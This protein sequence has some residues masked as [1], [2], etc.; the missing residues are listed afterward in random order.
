MSMKKVRWVKNAMKYIR[1]KRRKCD[2]WK[3]KKQGL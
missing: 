2:N 3:K 1:R